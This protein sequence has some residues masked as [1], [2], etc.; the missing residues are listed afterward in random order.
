MSRTTAAQLLFKVFGKQK[1]KDARVYFYLSNPEHIERILHVDAQGVRYATGNI[2]PD[3][4][5]Y[6]K[7]VS[8]RRTRRGIITVLKLDFQ[9]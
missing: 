8:T 7:K 3:F 1:F 4:E 6:V 9:P 5:I 2:D